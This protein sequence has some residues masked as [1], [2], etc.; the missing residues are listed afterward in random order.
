VLGLRY[1]EVLHGGFYFFTDP[2]DERAADLALDVEVASAAAFAQSH[3]AQLT[4]EMTLEGFAEH[5]R[6]EGTLVFD[7][8]QKRATYTLRFTAGDGAAYVL[9]GYKEL[10]VLNL[11]DSFTLVRASLYS[12]AAREV[13]RAVLRF[14]VRGGWKA[15]LR[16]VRLVA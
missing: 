3:V 2:V 10:E 4:G 16:S 15:L 5:V 7:R 11:V 9:R 13:G 6:V 1:R 14:D 12:D 8:E